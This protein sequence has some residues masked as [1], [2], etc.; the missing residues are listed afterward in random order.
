MRQIASNNLL[1]TIYVPKFYWITALE[2]FKSLEVNKRN[3][4]EVFNVISRY[5]GKSLTQKISITNFVLFIVIFNCDYSIS[6]YIFYKKLN[7]SN[8]YVYTVLYL[9]HIIQCNKASSNLYCVYTVII[10]N[11]F[12]VGYCFWQ[13]SIAL[14]KTSIVY[15]NELK[16]KS[17]EVLN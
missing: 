2:Q 3:I 4:F 16:G 14:T 17:G 11:Y 6:V 12:T 5:T 1:F 15:H 10:Y 9:F 13:S 8:K 7:K